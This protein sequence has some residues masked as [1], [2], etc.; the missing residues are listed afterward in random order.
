M[1]E[2]IKDYLEDF[3][4]EQEI[5]TILG[6]S[7]GRLRNRICEGGDHPP[8]IPGKVKR[9]PKV[10]FRKWDLSRLKRE[11]NRAS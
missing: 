10:E 11:I 2:K 6:I 3:Y 1:T 4:T 5:A 7:V 9:F 8:F